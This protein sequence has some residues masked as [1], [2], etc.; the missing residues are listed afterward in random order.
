V[1][2]GEGEAVYILKQPAILQKHKHKHNRENTRWLGASIGAA[3]VSKSTN[4]LV[5]KIQK[6]IL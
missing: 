1:G 5:K 3:W 4:N 2:G 6:T